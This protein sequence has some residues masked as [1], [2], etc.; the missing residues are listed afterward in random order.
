MIKTRSLTSA[1]GS[2]SGSGPDFKEGWRAYLVFLAG[3]R[4]GLVSLPDYKVH[5][6]VNRVGLITVYAY[7]IARL[8]VWQQRTW[9]ATISFRMALYQESFWTLKCVHVLQTRGHLKLLYRS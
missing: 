1:V 5:F 2:S 6:G 8:P 4:W 9:A 7:D 3:D